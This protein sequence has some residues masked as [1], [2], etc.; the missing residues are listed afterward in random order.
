[1]TSLDVRSLALRSHL[2]SGLK[3]EVHKL[4]VA[5]PI[6]HVHLNLSAP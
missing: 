3:K 5:P 6:L 4:G 2:S 1:M